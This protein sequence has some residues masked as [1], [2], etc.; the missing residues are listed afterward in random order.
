MNLELRSPKGWYS[1]MDGFGVWIMSSFSLSL[2]PF[3]LP[4]SLF[5]LPLRLWSQQHPIPQSRQ[6]LP[7]DRQAASLPICPEQAL[8]DISTAVQLC[9]GYR[10]W[11]L[12]PPLDTYPPALHW[13]SRWTDESEKMNGCSPA[14]GSFRVSWGRQP[15]KQDGFLSHPVRAL[16]SSHFL[17]HHFYDWRRAKAWLTPPV[18]LLRSVHW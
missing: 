9:P 18:F 8:L 1:D 6:A 4:L 10:S 5:P 13:A 15:S 2:P 17:G 11:P 3:L 14:I 12:L 16:Q 7:L